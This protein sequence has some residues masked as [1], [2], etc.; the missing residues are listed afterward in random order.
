MT[1]VST[2]TRVGSKTDFDSTDTYDRLSPYANSLSNRTNFS[3][4]T[5]YPLAKS[6]RAI[7]GNPAGG[8]I[9]VTYYQTIGAGPLQR[10]HVTDSAVQRNVGERPLRK[11]SEMEIIVDDDAISMETATDELGISVVGSG[12]VYPGFMPQIGDEFTYDYHNGSIGVFTVNDTELMSIHHDRFTKITFTLTRH[13]DL[14][15]S[16]LLEKWSSNEQRFV[17][18]KTQ[19]LQSNYTLLTE[20]AYID[21]SRL[22]QLKDIII[23]YYFREFYNNE[24]STIMSKGNNG[25]VD[26]VYD[27]Y[28]VKFLLTIVPQQVV[29][30]KRP[31][32][33]YPLVNDTYNYSI[34]ARFSDILNTD[35]S[36]LTRF[37]MIDRY[38]IRQRNVNVTGLMNREYIKLLPNIDDQSAIQPNVSP[39]YVFSTAFYAG[40]VESM[41]DFE[42][43][44]Y[45]GVTTR[46]VTDVSDFISRFV[47]NY[48]KGD[49]D[50][51][52]YAIPTILWLINLILA[53][54]LTQPIE[55]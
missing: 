20:Q 50:T 15:Y 39:D 4:G 37:Y 2:P 23:K 13:L 55:A 24:L 44:V 27:P 43:L 22:L 53:S 42:K 14:A 16:Q 34:W 6:G 46:A 11:I 26:G 51:Q 48:N 33:L 9:R 35:I 30:G 5:L 21:R 3:Q 52:F 54:Y 36:D 18:E 40:E 1:P 31:R 29:G 45:L 8:K 32:Q 7:L 49:K 38:I 10:D 17:F 25:F 47:N 19:Y 41:G 12:Y 28:L